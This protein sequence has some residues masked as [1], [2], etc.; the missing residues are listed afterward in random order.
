MFNEYRSSYPNHVHQ[1]AV[2]PSKHYYL[3][4]D[5]LLRYQQKPFEIKLETLAR[6]KKRHMVMYALRDHYTDLYYAEVSFGVEL[7]SLEGFLG[8]AWH[9][10]PGYPFCGLPEI[11]ML[12]KNV[13][14]AFPGIVQAVKAEDVHLIPATSGYQS[15]VPT[16]TRKIETSLLFAKNSALGKTG[17][18][19]DVDD[20]VRLGMRYNAREK[21]RMTSKTK[22][23]LWQQHVDKIR[24]PSSGFGV[25]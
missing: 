5:G 2:T 4:Q 3:G 23:D 6:S 17:T 7:S 18:L 16:M 11:L 25:A 10:K 24:L 14:N 1:V 21:L 15:G 13:I 9:K 20:A 12:P 22:L 19:D 8:R